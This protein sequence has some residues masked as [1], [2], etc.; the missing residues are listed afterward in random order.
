VDVIV[1]LMVIAWGALSGAFL[2]PYLYGLF[3]RRATKAG[4]YAGMISG[5]GTAVGLFCYWG[6]PHIPV[7]AAI[8]MLVPLLVM[9]VVSLLTSPPD[10][11][12]LAKCF[13]AVKGK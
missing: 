4:A 6:K 11:A 5:V 2:A 13:P 12:H 1:N 7:S 8:A 10:G 3:W 9:P